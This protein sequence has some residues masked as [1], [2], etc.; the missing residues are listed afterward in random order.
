MNKL[1]GKFVTIGYFNVLF[2]LEINEQEAENKV[3][4]LIQRI[5][6][7]DK[8]NMKNIYEW[9]R[10]QNVRVFA[11]FVYR[12]DFPISANLWNFYSYLR[13]RYEYSISSRENTLNVN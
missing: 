8:M 3:A 6:D 11:K 4:Y 2:Y 12:K 5:K 13:G 10:N 7:G 1:N 9:C